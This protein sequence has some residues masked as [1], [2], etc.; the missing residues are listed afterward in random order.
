M[1]GIRKRISTGFLSIIALLFISGM[2]SLFELNSL[3]QDTNKILS[4]NTHNIELAKAMLDAAQ[5]QNTAFIHISV[6]KERD[7]D[8]LAISSMDRL[9][10]TLRAAQ[11]AALDKA[12]LDSL[13]SATSQIRLLTE[14][15]LAFGTVADSLSLS[16]ENSWYRQEYE[17]HYE[18]LTSAIKNYMT[19]TKGS[20]APHAEKLQNN[21]YRAVTP[22][23][24]SL[25]VMIATV[26]MLFYFT[27]IYCVKPIVN[28][29]KSLGNYISFRLPFDVKTVCQDE[30]LELKNRIDELIIENKKLKNK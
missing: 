20:L 23:L 27:I 9:E 21:A 25:L 8:S 14:S 10:Q 11:E 16:A 30:V 22:V 1:T 2:I 17:P 3:S 15:Y 28:I 13:A 7:Y 26:M 29:N 12:H 18:R 24:I 4:T 19:S 5:D 6:F